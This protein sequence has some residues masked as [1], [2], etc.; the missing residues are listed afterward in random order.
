MKI[1]KGFS[2]MEVVVVISILVVVLSIT[3]Y[4]FPKLNK[5]EVLE[6]DVS[7]VVALIRNARVL[8]VAS[9]NT[10]PF[11]IHFENNKIVLF[12][13]GAYV[14][15]NDNEKIVTLSKDVYMSGY[16]LNL[17]SPDIVFSRLIGNTSN[18]GTV[19]FSLKDDSASTTITILGTGVIQ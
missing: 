19:T 9:K 3:F 13:G 18:Y 16:L 14:A 1:N 10:S 17:G 6:K 11:G 5:K 2:L 12:E 8:S 7:S 4:F 15:G